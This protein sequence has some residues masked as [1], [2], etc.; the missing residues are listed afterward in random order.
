MGNDVL[1]SDP[2][3]VIIAGVGG[4]GN[5]MASRVLAGMLTRKGFYVTVGES[6][7]GT[8]RGGSV[9]S[10]LRISRDSI[11]S[12]QIPRGGAHVLVGMEATEAIRILADYGNPEIKVICNTR[13]VKPVGVI[14]G[15]LSYPSL[16]EIREV[17]AGL[18]KKTWFIDATD[19]AMKM[20]GPIFG[21]IILMGA[22]CGIKV[23]P[24]E[25]DD[26]EAVI[27]EKVA[28]GKLEVNLRAF[29]LGYA[30]VGAD[31]YG[32]SL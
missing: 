3:N 1:T 10:H 31:H 24:V 6:F 26:F 32:G 21:N 2:Y 23:L 30:I 13:P 22:F 11:W 14:A 28:A 25:R 27:S 8:Q 16:P 29:D 5:V 17:M 20:G 9:S 7:G 4:Q 19:E 12:P 18:T 15:E